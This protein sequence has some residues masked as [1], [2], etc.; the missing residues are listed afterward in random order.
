MREGSTVGRHDLGAGSVR[1]F[2][3][4]QIELA[5]TFA[6]QAVIAIENVRLFNELQRAI[7]SCSSRLPPPMRSR[8]SAA[9]PSTCKPVLDTLVRDRGEA[10]RCRQ[11]GHRSADGTGTPV[12]RPH[13]ASFSPNSR[14]IEDAPA[15]RPDDDT[16]TGRAGLEGRTM[17]VADVQV[18]PEYTVSALSRC[19]P[20]P[21][22]ARCAA[23]SRGGDDRRCHR[24]VQA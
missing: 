14:I 9:R 3:D 17:H 13:P 24:P 6:D 19:W 20:D 5:E 22:G 15:S 1:P 18:D 23:C 2:T 10:L 4:K 11:E 12:R 7:I 16:M 21:D 8:S